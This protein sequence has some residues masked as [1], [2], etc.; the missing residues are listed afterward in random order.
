MNTTEDTWFKAMV[1][2]EDG[3]AELT[4]SGIG[5]EVVLAFS[6]KGFATFTEVVAAAVPV[7]GGQ[8]ILSVP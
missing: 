4:V 6:P 8:S 5:S 3:S 2:R 1:S 7:A